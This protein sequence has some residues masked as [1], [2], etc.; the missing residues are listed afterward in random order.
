M[1]RNTKY[2]GIFSFGIGII[3]IKEQNEKLLIHLHLE[4][5]KF[6][7]IMTNILNQDITLSR[8]EDILIIEIK[9]N[10]NI[11]SFF[12]DLGIPII[13][14]VECCNDFLYQEKLF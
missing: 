3:E 11:Y 6:T 4:N 5:S 9:E 13:N 7:Q 12:E 10:T 1:E 8:L 14:L 2:L